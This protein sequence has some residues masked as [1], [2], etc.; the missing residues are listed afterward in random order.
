M[1]LA[2]IAVSR[3][4]RPVLIIKKI[5]TIT[6]VSGKNAF[7]CLAVS[8]STVEPELGPLP[9]FP[10]KKPAIFSGLNNQ[11]SFT[12]YGKRAGSSREATPLQHGRKMQFSKQADAADGKK[13]APPGQEEPEANQIRK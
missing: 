11:L 2:F 3:S 12:G 5:A 4:R 1:T 9:D 6:S 13:M 10:V 7:S 8:A